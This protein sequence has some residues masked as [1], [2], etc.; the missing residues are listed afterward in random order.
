MPDSL[1]IATALT[2]AVSITVA[3]RAIPFIAKNAVKHSPLLADLGR[4]TP[5]GAVT[6]LAMYC[7]AAIDITDPTHEA[8]PL[9][10]VAVTAGVHVWRH[11]AVLSI[12]AGTGACLLVTN[13]L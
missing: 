11:N 4:W 3:L 13:G 12:V 10:G 6:I 9:A 2:V 5:L 8:G 7:L 1:Y